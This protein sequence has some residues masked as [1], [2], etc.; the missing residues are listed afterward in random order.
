MVHN[1]S[2]NA[3][4]SPFSEKYK[5]FT[6]LDDAVVFATECGYVDECGM[7]ISDKEGMFNF[8]QSGDT[9]VSIIVLKV[10]DWNNWTSS[11]LMG[12]SKKRNE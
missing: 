6:D 8:H 2:E 1:E 11:T 10:E 5:L 9:K 4:Y 12:G 7:G 3:R